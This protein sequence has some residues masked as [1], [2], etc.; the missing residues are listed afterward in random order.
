M[1][2]VGHIAPSE[3]RLR[4]IEMTLKVAIIGMGIMGK[5]VACAIARNDLVR[6]AAVSEVSDDRRESARTE[7]GLER[8]Y[9]DYL[10]MLEKEKPEAVF[11]AT[12][13]WAHFDPVMACLDRGVHVHVEKPMTTLES[14][15]AAIVRKVRDTGLKLQ[16]SYN[17][18]WLAPYHLVK[19]RLSKREV[20]LPLIGYARKNNPISVPTKMLATWAKES[21]PMW[22]QSSH[23]IDLMCW[24]FDDTPEEVTCHGVKRVLRERFGWDTWDGL[25]G[26]VRFSKGGVA[27]FEAAWIFPETHPSMPDSF[28]SLVAEKGHFQIDRKSE[29]VEMSSEDRFHWPR[30]LLNYKVFDRWIGAFPSCINSFIDAILEDRETYVTEMDGWRVT[31]TLEALHRSAETEKSVRVS[32]NPVNDH[33]EGDEG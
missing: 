11:I 29:A 4:R 25:Q 12:P 15:S 3:R 9:S 8:V 32:S 23:D 2:E 1:S 27:T 20:G 21:S 26:L 19:D 33:R 28:M 6:L 18:R 5:Q 24:W 10:E 16:V 13:D 7:F 22:F 30:S 14:E 17:H 31:A